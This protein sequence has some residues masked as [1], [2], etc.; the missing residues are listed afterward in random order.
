MGV[1]DVSPCH[2]HSARKKIM[3][4]QYCNLL[5]PKEIVTAITQHAQPIER[6]MWQVRFKL[7]M[8][9][10]K[11]IESSSDIVSFSSLGTCGGHN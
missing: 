7:N 3:E 5:I 10:E 2:V 1:S 4:I 11:R 9:Q 8:C 6:N